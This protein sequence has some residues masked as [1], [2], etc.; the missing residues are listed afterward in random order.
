M[1]LSNYNIVKII[2]GIYYFSIVLFFLI[3]FLNYQ[4]EG[5]LFSSKSNF[6]FS[7]SAIAIGLIYIYFS[8]KYFEY[9]GGGE[10]IVFS[11]KGAILSNFFNYR[12]NTIEIERHKIVGYEIYNFLIYKRLVI[13]Y[14]SHKRTRSK[15]CNITILSPKKINYLRQSLDKLIS[16]NKL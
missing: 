16:K 2:P 9:E 12:G 1:R 3:I 15:H 13:D 6:Y 4:L 11:N 5:N 7:L 10:I 8:W 14:K